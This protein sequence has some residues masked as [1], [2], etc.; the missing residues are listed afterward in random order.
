MTQ[1]WAF[2]LRRDGWWILYSGLQHD[3]SGMLRGVAWFDHAGAHPPSY[4]T[5]WEV[6]VTRLEHDD[7]LIADLAEFG[8][9]VR[10][11]G[12]LPF[13]APPATSEYPR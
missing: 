12:D 2:A 6:A 3:P 7:Q 8:V 9:H 10:E 5:G 11:P 1:R 4:G 13:E